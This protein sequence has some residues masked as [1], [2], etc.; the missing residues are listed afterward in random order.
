MYSHGL[1]DP[2]V[3]SDLIPAI[4]VRND[5]EIASNVQRAVLESEGL[6]ACVRVGDRIDIP[7]RRVLSNWTTQGY[8][9]SDQQAMH[10]R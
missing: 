4:V 6:S 10:T 1:V 3:I 2:N 9:E 5:R 7:R 8:H